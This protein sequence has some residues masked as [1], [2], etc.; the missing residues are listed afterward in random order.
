MEQP[1]NDSMREEPARSEAEQQLK[2]VPGT[3][4]TGAHQEDLRSRQDEHKIKRGNTM[5]SAN[6]HSHQAAIKKNPKNYI[7]L[8]ASVKEERPKRP[9]KVLSKTSKERAR[10][11]WKVQSAS[12]QLDARGAPMTLVSEAADRSERS[13]APLLRQTSMQRK[14]NGSSEWARSILASKVGLNCHMALRDQ[15]RPRIPQE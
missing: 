11:R 13:R 1:E 8:A 7:E 10:E 3:K 6:S 5:R 14:R 2:Q 15:E 4:T 9:Q 12:V